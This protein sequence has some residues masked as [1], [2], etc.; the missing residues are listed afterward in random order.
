MGK[1]VLTLVLREVDDNHNAVQD[2]QVTSYLESD[3]AWD[4]MLP[5]FLHFL[6]GAGY[7]GVVERMEQLLGGSVYDY[8]T[9]INSR[10]GEFDEE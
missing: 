4:K 9:Y 1:K 2:T 8:E 10:V 5:F 7:V 3:A 6:E